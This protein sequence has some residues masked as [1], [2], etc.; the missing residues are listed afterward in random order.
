MAKYTHIQAILQWFVK[1]DQ[2]LLCITQMARYVQHSD[3]TKTVKEL[4]AAKLHAK[5]ITPDTL[6][7]VEC[8]H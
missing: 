2:S 1:H 7:A 4:A 6:V 5:L 8:D 3:N